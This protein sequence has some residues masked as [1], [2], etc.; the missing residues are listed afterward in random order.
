M[1]KVEFAEGPSQAILHEIVGGDGIARECSR[2]APQPRNLGFDIAIDFM[3]GGI[4]AVA[5]GRNA[6]RDAGDFTEGL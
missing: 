3:Q 5:I 6:D 1:P 2:I 4:S